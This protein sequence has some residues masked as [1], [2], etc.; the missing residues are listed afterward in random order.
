[1]KVSLFYKIEST[2]MLVLDSNNIHLQINSTINPEQSLS[3]LQK[4][5]LH[6]YLVHKAT[7]S[8]IPDA[9]YNEWE[10]HI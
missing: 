9:N 8:R 2:S 5:P 4:W 3:I 1:M 7:Q 10:K 6:L